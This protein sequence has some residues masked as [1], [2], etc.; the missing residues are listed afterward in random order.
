MTDSVERYSGRGRRN[1]RF[2]A[3]APVDIENRLSVAHNNRANCNF[4]VLRQRP[5][6]QLCNAQYLCREARSSDR[7]ASQLSE[8]GSQALQRK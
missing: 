7:R 6:W 4:C 8:R 1:S 3:R 5:Q 2:R